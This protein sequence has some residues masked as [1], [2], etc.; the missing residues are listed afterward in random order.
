MLLAQVRDDSG[1]YWDIG[2]GEQKKVGGLEIRY[3]C[4][5][6]ESL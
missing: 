4:R 1:L 2:S 6:P 5:N 3:G